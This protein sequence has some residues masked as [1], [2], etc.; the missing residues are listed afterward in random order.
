MDDYLAQYVKPDSL[1]RVIGQLKRYGWAILGVEKK[2]WA[3]VY[4]GDILVTQL[5][6][7]IVRAGRH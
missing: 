5:E 4:R 6:G 1:N 2:R 7:W 3:R